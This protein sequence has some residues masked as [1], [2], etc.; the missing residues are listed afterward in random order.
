[1]GA[2][3]SSDRIAATLYVFL[4]DM[5]CL[6]NI[7][8]III[9]IIIIITIKA[10]RPDT[11]ET[12]LLIDIPTP[13]DSNLYTHT[14]THTNEKLSKYK[15]VDDDDDD[16][17]GDKIIIWL[18]PEAICSFLLSVCFR[19]LVVMSSSFPYVAVPSL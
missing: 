14:H 8:I 6:R 15:D 1:V 3:N 19:F 2:M 12:C 5:V 10:N 11:E 9:I 17:D 16:D 18:F 4:R 13:F 7:C